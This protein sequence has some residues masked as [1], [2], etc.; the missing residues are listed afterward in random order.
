MIGVAIAVAGGML[1][2]ASGFMSASLLFLMALFSALFAWF[3]RR[4]SVV[5]VVIIFVSACRFIIALP[6]FPANSVHQQRGELEGRQVDLVGRVSDFPEFYPYKSGNGGT[7]TFGLECEGMLVSNAWKRIRGE[8]EVRITGVSSS[9]VSVFGQRVRVT[10]RI[11]RNSMPRRAELELNVFRVSDVVCL[12]EC[13]VWSPVAWG[14]AWRDKATL[15][16]EK[17]LNGFSVQKSVLKALVLGYRKEVPA[18]QI[19][20]F[21]RTGSVHIFAISGLHVGIV[22]F[23]LI[24]VLKAVGIP[25]DW[26]GV[27]LLPLLG[28]YVV[29]TGMKSSAVRALTMAAVFILAPLFRRKPDIPTSVAFAAVLLLVFQPLEILSAGFIFS[30]AVV[31][32]IVMVY[33]KVP[34]RWVQGGRVKRYIVSLVITSMA[35]SLAAIPLAALYFGTFSPIALL[36]NLIVVPLTFCIV[37]CGWLSI[38]VPVASEIFNYAAVVFIDLLLGS[39]GWL[40]RLPGSSIQVLSPPLVAVILWFGSLTYLFVQAR[41]SGQKWGAVGLA[42]AAVGLAI[43]G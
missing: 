19:A 6:G 33:T 22:G 37:L 9:R 24:I 43:L 26:F 1:L 7:W 18:E 4:K 34:E 16:L 28:M 14:R 39:V 17:G 35:A 25:R 32:F 36:G 30:F 21:C 13:P 29:S 40:D 15:N 5:Y 12:S 31:A 23:F 42:G 3:V 38:L 27:W 20:E 8:I 10:G 11:R 41:T 2:A